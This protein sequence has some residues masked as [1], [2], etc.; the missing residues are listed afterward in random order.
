MLNNPL[1][2][3]GGAQPPGRP[4][5]HKSDADR[6]LFNVSFFRNVPAATI[7]RLDRLCRW[8]ELKKGDVLVDAG[9]NRGNVFFLLHGELRF[10][11][12]T[13]T[14]KLLSLPAVPPGGFIGLSALTRQVMPPYSVDA[15]KD[16]VVASLNARSFWSV[17]LEDPS[18]VQALL[19]TASQRIESLI[20][21]I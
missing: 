8:L 11:L 10:F 2:E 20:R 5:A 6:T 15:A 14:G 4:N 19:M 16:T 7:E 12:Y 3:N 1:D 17:V 9:G 13:E 21:K 18:L